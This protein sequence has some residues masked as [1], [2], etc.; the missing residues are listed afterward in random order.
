ML[1]IVK[2]HAYIVA[3]NISWLVFF[4]ID[5]LIP[6]TS[7]FEMKWIAWGYSL[8]YVLLASIIGVICVRL[9]AERLNY[10]RNESSRLTQKEINF[11]V[12]FT[13][14]IALTGLIFLIIDRLW[15]QQIDYSKG[16]AFARM[17][18]ISQGEARTGVSSLFSVLGNLSVPFIYVPLSMVYLQWEKLGRR[19]RL[20]AIPAILFVLLAF[21]ALYGG[22][23]A[24]LLGLTVVASISLI[25]IMSG[26]MILPAFNRKAY[27]S[28]LCLIIPLL[29]FV[30]YIVR[31]RVKM[32]DMDSYSYAVAIIQGLCGLTT[33]RFEA[34]RYLGEPFADVLYWLITVGSYIIHS[35]WSFEGVLAI[36][37]RPGTALFVTFLELLHRIG[38]VPEQTHWLFWY[39]YINLP[40]AV[41][42][43]F[44]MIGYIVVS[45]LHG[46]LLGLSC[47]MTS[48]KQADG[49]GVLFILS[50]IVIS[51]LSP[52][53]F[54]AQIFPFVF[55]I[56]A[57]TVT[58]FI[59]RITLGKR[60]W[61]Y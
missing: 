40:G 42:Y 43:D 52:M 5:L 49:L 55:L 26:K 8:G 2:S 50:V 28:I 18:W 17:Q 9:F 7:V 47:L 32:N 58:H 30:V 21:S 37:E 29:I 34:I 14:L 59:V 3:F 57:F 6:A 11:I 1:K 35:M 4:I 41:W 46:G 61:I 20:I 22:R 38:L 10:S 16:I 56:F 44:G 39:Q 24:I 51:L 33:E 53:C 54:A 45:I 27:V 13:F 25:R 36:P 31:E 12:L 48:R 15:V 23:T 60:T 19:L